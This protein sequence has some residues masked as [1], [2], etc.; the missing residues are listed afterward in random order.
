[1][2]QICDC[3]QTYSIEKH[4]DNFVIYHGRCP[5]R[6]GFK[7]ATLSDLSFNCDIKHLRECLIRGDLTRNEHWNP[8][9]AQFEKAL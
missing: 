9:N 6:H 4:G 2:D 7:L 8:G 3:E 1:M 5:H